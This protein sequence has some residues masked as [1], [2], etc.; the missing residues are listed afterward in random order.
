[1]CRQEEG[2]QRLLRVNFDPALVRVLREVHY[3]L[4]LPDLPQQVPAPA[5]KVGASKL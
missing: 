4:L 3:F 2:G 5:L 1:M